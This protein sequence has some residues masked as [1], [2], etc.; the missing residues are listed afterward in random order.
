VHGVF[1]L[2]E[3][4]RDQHGFRLRSSP[5][6]FIRWLAL[7]PLPGALFSCFVEYGV[8]KSWSLASNRSP[9]RLLNNPGT[10]IWGGATPPAALPFL[11]I[12]MAMTRQAA[13]HLEPR[14]SQLVAPWLFNSLLAARP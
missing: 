2:S 12:A 4:D 6:C 10:P 7:M 11:A 3:A 14:R 13:L 1:Y 8:E 5:M 9:R